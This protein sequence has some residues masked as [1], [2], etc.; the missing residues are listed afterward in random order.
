MEQI[1]TAAHIGL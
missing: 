1:T